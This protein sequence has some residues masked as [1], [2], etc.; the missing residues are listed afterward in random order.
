MV[1]T[2]ARPLV[3]LLAAATLVAGCS[4]DDGG[5]DAAPSPDVTTPAPTLTG[6]AATV[7]KAYAAYSSAVIGARTTDLQNLVTASTPVFYGKL[8]DDALTADKATLLKRRLIDQVTVLLMRREWDPSLL[9]TA[10]PAEVLA[11]AARR[12]LLPA[13][14][15]DGS[16]G[17][18]DLKGTTATVR[19][20]TTDPA[21]ITLVQEGGT[22]RADVPTSLDTSEEALE[23]N[24]T[25]VKG[26]R[27]RLVEATLLQA[28][29]NDDTAAA[30]T[31]WTPLGR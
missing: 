31:L 30:E 8:R 9:R 26:D 22:W 17:G 10:A 21:A 27:E 1:K 11:E 16:L 15:P 29:P 25:L 20:N 5:G 23:E 3:A 18:V 24:L 13:G 4:G 14:Q 6:E 7:Q 2:W 19:V 12:K 28:G